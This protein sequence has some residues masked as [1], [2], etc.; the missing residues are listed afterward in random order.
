MMGSIWEYER[1]TLKD[2]LETHACTAW[3][4]RCV[5]VDVRFR[6]RYAYVDIFDGDLW[7]MPGPTKDEKE[8]IRQ[9]SV[10]MCWLGWTSDMEL[11]DL[12]FYRYSD[13]RYQPSIDFDG[14]GRSAPEACF[15]CA[16]QVY[17][18]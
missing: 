12:A 7:F 16:V 1:Q 3:G 5:G 6:A 9:T 18:Q 17:L 4:E 10:K 8:Q 11:W 14:L 2:R 13:S 15:D